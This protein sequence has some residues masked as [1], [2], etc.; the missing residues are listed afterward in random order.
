MQTTKSGFE[1]KFLS[2]L[3][4]IDPRRIRDYLAQLLS[5]KNF[6]ETIFDHLSEGIIVTDARQRLIYANPFARRM[7]GVAKPKNLIGEPLS[8]LWSEGP[9]RDIFRALQSLPREIQGY[10]CPFGANL[11]RR[12]SITSIPIQ[13]PTGDTG[14]EEEKTWAFIL[15]DVTERSRRMEEQSRA[16]RLSSLALLTSGVAH[17]I[18]NPLNS[19]NIHAQILEQQSREAREE[20]AQLDPEK[21]ERAAKVILDET[22][23]L[24]NVINE[25]LQAARPQSPMIQRKYLGRVI[26]DLG[27]VFA[28]ECAQA[29]IE[30]KTDLDPEMPPIDMDAHL[31]FQALRNLVRNAIDAH[32]EERR[33]SRD[34]SD[35]KPHRMVL[36]RTRLEGDRATVEIADNGPGVPEEAIDK[37]F[38][39]YYTTKSEGTGLG[40][41][42]VYRIVAQ[43]H[44]S[45][46]A[47]S[48]P[49]AGTRFVISLP[50]AERPV[51]LLSSTAGTRAS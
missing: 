17:E 19:L 34:G 24:T 43:H 32:L 5:R 13:T 37:I 20:S 12:L 3:G 48:Q 51:R 39:P 42:V 30:W 33:E 4:K 44:G 49:G 27:R 6:F 2:K 25:F 45:I 9:V 40:L 22:A 28:P 23:R 14:E 11:E 35:L 47:D 15:A 18:K 26:E 50:L 38:E 29:G 36:V 10:E 41:M 7:L 1:D 31:I 8:D 21:V 46:H 16:Q